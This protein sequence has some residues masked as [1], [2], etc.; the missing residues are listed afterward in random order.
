[1]GRNFAELIPIQESGANLYDVR[2]PC[3]KKPLCY[4]FAAETTGSSRDG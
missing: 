1:M 2:K 4:D 3:V